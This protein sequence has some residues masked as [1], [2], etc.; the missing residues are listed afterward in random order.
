MDNLPA[1]APESQA[2]VP[3]AASPAVVPFYMPAMTLA[4]AKQR[5]E[6]FVQFVSECLVENLD[7]GK[8]PGSDKPA[9]LKPG[10]E[11]LGTLFGLVPTFSLIEKIEDWS[12]TNHPEPFFYYFYKCQLW[13]GGTVM[14]AEADGSASSAESKYRYRWV[15]AHDVQ[16]LPCGQCKRWWPKAAE[17]CPVCHISLVPITALRSRGG[18]RSEF[19]FAIEKAETSGPYG[20]PLQYWQEW[21]QAI[22]SGIAV[23]VEKPTRNGKMLQAYEMDLSMYR[24][25][26]ED[27]ADQVNT[28]QKMAQKRAYVAAILIATNA[29]EF[30]TQD[31]EEFSEETAGARPVGDPPALTEEGIGEKG[32]PL[33][34]V[35]QGS[36]LFR[37]V[38]KLC[39]VTP[40]D[41]RDFLRDGLGT[42][43]LDKCDAYSKLAKLRMVWDADQKRHGSGKEIILSGASRW[44]SS[45]AGPIEPAD[46]S[47]ATKKDSNRNA[48]HGV[49]PLILL[50]AQVGRKAGSDGI[51][52]LNLYLDQQFGR[53]DVATIQPDSETGKR[54]LQALE[55]LDRLNARQLSEILRTPVEEEPERTGDRLFEPEPEYPD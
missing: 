27:I 17:S 4:E 7:Y 9:L 20:K 40:N 3:S 1:V 55:S 36:R 37:D 34:L 35:E 31:V 30:F 49:N 23:P 44:R 43:D 50:Y 6:L 28:I 45:Q 12:G 42:A 48:Q 51:R 24:V 53:H 26:N 39:G 21:A 8:V 46:P 41:V 38:V 13:R 16:I 32:R 5:R 22:D 25:L 52:M 29:S 18:K 54:L 11:K 2:A 14:I 47:P 19:A 33:D 10:A 15:L